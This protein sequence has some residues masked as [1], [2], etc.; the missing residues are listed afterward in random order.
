MPPPF[1]DEATLNAFMGLN[2][3]RCPTRPEEQA[4]IPYVP[5]KPHVVWARLENQS[6]QN[7]IPRVA[8]VGA[9]GNVYKLEFLTQAEAG[10]RNDAFE[11]YWVPYREN[12]PG[13]LTILGNDARFM[14]TARMSGCSFGLGSYT[15]GGVVGAA[16]VNAMTVGIATAGS[17]LV[18]MEAQKKAQRTYLASHG[19]TNAANALVRRV[20]SY[21]N[22]ML[23]TQGNLDIGMSSTTFGVHQIGGDWRFYTL[24]YRGVG[25]NVTH[26][27]VNLQ[28]SGVL[29]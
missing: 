17:D 26:S 9:A 21:D 20:I 24:R 22:Y 8:L 7:A 12:C 3:V 14:F 23:D 11:T 29:Q 15:A 4:N 27:G 2:V 18:K 10:N 25:L 28:V 19:T 6:G 13:T 1:T 16:H 5:T